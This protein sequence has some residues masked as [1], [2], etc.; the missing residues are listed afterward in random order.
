[1]EETKRLLL[2][3]TDDLKSTMEE[4]M[5]RM[6]R[7]MEGMEKKSEM[8]EA[9][10]VSNQPQ[11]PL[12]EEVLLGQCSAV[13]ELDRSLAQPDRRNQMK[14]FLES[15]GG[16]N[17]GAAVHRILRQVATN[18]VLGQYSLRGRR[19]KKAFQNLAFCK[20]ITE[21]CMQNF[22]VMKV[23]DIE[24]CIGHALKFAP[25]RWSAGPQD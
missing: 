17:P 25:H 7:R 12:Q 2:R 13:E 10:V 19:V 5:G 20:V 14:R 9:A 21:A 18:H 4:H 16:A 15:L 8:L 11:P 6:T 24:E 1:M 22:P 3:T 23:A